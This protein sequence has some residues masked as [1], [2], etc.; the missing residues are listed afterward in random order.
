MA[1]ELVVRLVGGASLVSLRGGVPCCR[2]GRRLFIA[3][4]S[5]W[6]GCLISVVFRPVRVRFVLVLGCCSFRLRSRPLRPFRLFRPS[7]GRAFSGLLAAS[8]RACP[9]RGPTPTP[10]PT[11]SASSLALPA[12]L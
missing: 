8:L 4:S 2:G 5:S 11:S 3:F 7:G 6:V 9:S 1:G 12:I 10:K